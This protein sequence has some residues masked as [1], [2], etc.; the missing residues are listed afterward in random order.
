M[1]ALCQRVE[2]VSGH[3][4]AYQKADQIREGGR[5]RSGIGTEAT[6]QKQSI[7]AQARGYLPRPFPTSQ[8][9]T[10]RH[11]T[12]IGATGLLGARRLTENSHF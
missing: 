12:S 1:L 4:L 11:T 10:R 7:Y 9:D 2:S 6:E 5:L 3:F 8:P